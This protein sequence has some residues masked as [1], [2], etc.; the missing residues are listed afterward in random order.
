MSKTP[1]RKAVTDKERLDHLLMVLNTN[2][3][4]GCNGTRRWS[5]AGIDAVLIAK[6]TP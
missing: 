6:E 2:P 4:T 1:K 5:R 3:V